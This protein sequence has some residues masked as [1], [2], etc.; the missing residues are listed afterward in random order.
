M[1]ARPIVGTVG[2]N[3]TL[4]LTSAVGLGATM[5]LVGV[6]LPSL[7][8]RDGLDSMGLAALAALPFLASLVTLF[9]GR[10]GPRT[11]SRMAFLRATGVLGLLVVL[12]APDPIFIALATLGFWVTFALGAPLQQRIWATVYPTEQRGR[13]LGFIGTGRSAAGTLA[14]LAIT[15][16]AASSGWAVIVIV[17]ALVGALC[18]L[19]IGR[20]EVP[21]IDMVH[22]FSAADSIRSVLEVP[23]LR[24][25]VAA[26][27]LFGAGFLAAPALIAMVHVDRLGLGLD[28]IALAGLVGYGTT[29]LTFSL[30]GRLASRN[31]GA[32]TISVGTAAGV[33]AL[34]LFAFAPNMA[35]LIAAT[36]LLG[37]AGA[38]V[39]VSWPLLIAEYASLERQSA[40]SAGMNSIMAVRGLVTPF[41]IMTPLS[42]GLT[43]EVGG[44]LLCAAL[45]LA[46]MLVYSRMSGLWD[47]GVAAL[48]QLSAW[49][50]TLVAQAGGRLQRRP[51]MLAMP[52]SSISGWPLRR[53]SRLM[54]STMAGWVLNRPRALWSSFFTGLTK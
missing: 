31:G 26:Q 12:V 16:A 50:G 29:A 1:P 41:I 34:V 53:R 25:M 5:A 9:A 44:L 45:G 13:L 15:V 11:P 10:I 28:Q 20:M 36:A 32:F 46:G 19:A 51:A 52:V 3:L 35:V 17:V 6:L 39:D 18:S 7:A 22:R 8:R 4:D 38:S 47:V 54:R 14:L 21:G 2:R 30:W 37:T 49:L 43:N 42:T 33:L 48:V 24:R 27:L 23:M 40:V